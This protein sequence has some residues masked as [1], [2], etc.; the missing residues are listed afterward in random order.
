MK[1]VQRNPVRGSARRPRELSGGQRQR[2]AL[3]R[4]IVRQP[5]VFLTNE[6]LSNL[7]AEL[8]V[9][10]RVPLR[11]LHHESRVPTL[12]VPPDQTEAMTL[13]DRVVIRTRIV[14]RLM[15]QQRRSRCMIRSRD[16]RATPL[17]RKCPITIGSLARPSPVHRRAPARA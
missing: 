2:V 16:P 1:D 4:A 10:T 14:L 6:P 3:A 15:R 7:D 17:A 11:S 8:R 12:E 5:A 9:S 13:A